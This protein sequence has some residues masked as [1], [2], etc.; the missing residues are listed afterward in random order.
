M[1]K[2]IR[3]IFLI[4]IVIIISF[5]IYISTIG[6]KTDKFNSQII[7]QIK[8]FDKNLNLELKEVNI[9]F[10]PL[11]LN[12]NLKTIG[13]NII[14]KEKKIQL[15]SIKSTISVKSLFN[16]QFLL[17]N[18]KI[19]TKSVDIKNLLSFFR[20]FK[21][22]A[23]LYL[24]ERLIKKGNVLGNIYV[25]FDDNGKIKNNFRIDG[26]VKNG[27]ITSIKKYQLDKINFK[28]NFLKNEFKFNDISINLNDNNIYSPEL[29][30]QKKN[31]KFYVI[32]K[33]NS[34]KISL[35]EKQISN[36]I[37]LNN[38]NLSISGIEFTINND[39]SFE[40]DQKY[41]IKNFV[42]NFIVNIENLILKNQY[43]Y[44]NFFPNLKKNIK[45]QKHKV[46]ISYKKDIVDIKG[47]GNVLFQENDDKIEYAIK[48][49]KKD[50]TFDIK[51]NVFKN[52]FNFDLLN[53]KKKDDKDLEIK[54][55][56][57]K[58]FDG[59]TI[60]E[61][62][63]LIDKSNIFQI[64]KLILTNDNKI[65]KFNKLKLD[66]VDSQSIKNQISITKT[67]K[68][69]HLDS[70]SFNASKLIDNFLKPD[71]KNFKD[72]FTD[73]LKLKMN[74]KKTYLDKQ[75]IIRNLRGHLVLGN[76]EIIDANITSQFSDEKKIRFTIKKNDN[77]KITTFFSDLAKPFVDKYKFIKGFEDGSIDFYSVKK[78]DI[79]NSILKIY[80]FKLQELPTLTKVL[81]L[82]SLQG[83]A[84]ILSG[85]GIRF[86]EFEMNFSNENNLMKIN[87]IYSIGP[88]ISVLMSGYIENN[89][90][91]SLRGTLV[92]ATTLNKTIGSI[93]FIGE[94]LVGKKVGEGVFGVSFKI[95]GT[96]DN[97]ETTVNPIKTLT[98][99]FITRTLE[100]IKQN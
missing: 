85:E 6:I 97:L 24:F 37:N 21:N 13:T 80:D 82:A 70:V 93:P 65:R 33:A 61:K 73:N 83:I 46:F 100:K 48:K 3:N 87:E 66:Y 51:L 77:E 78:N 45:F 12:V 49:T 50:F 25:E 39:F 47:S 41:K 60:F 84:D 7:N 71:S 54:L 38:S 53:Y 74:I 11:T 67:K 42:S 94:I 95:K 79:K 15:A 69:Y 17:T 64:E 72:I 31:D 22:D 30:A 5:L 36:L 86:N 27:K 40:I 26:L 91:I 88:A 76:N 99:R 34:Q 23:K 1:I 18:L 62:I 96:P 9:I 4:F 8:T 10:S 63:L 28:F 89:K 68:N 52:Q 58:V 59:I 2:L 57:K 55:I 43:E 81:T 92:P 29:I 75:N 98:P 56:G 20:L 19:S 44:I 35:K 16:N 32:G 14:F 90:L